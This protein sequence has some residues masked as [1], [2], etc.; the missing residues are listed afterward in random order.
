MAKPNVLPRRAPNW[1]TCGVTK[2]P[3]HRP[4]SKPLSRHSSRS[5]RSINKRPNRSLLRRESV[6]R[7]SG[8][9]ART[10][11]EEPQPPSPAMHEA[12]CMICNS[13]YREEMDELFV[14]WHN[15]SEI[16]REYNTPR[17]TLYRHAHAVGLFPHP[18]SQ[19][20][21]FPGTHHPSRRNRPV[22]N[23][24]LRD[25]RRPHPRSH[26]RNRRVGQPAHARH[27]LLRNGRARKQNRASRARIARHTM[28]SNRKRKA[29]KTNHGASRRVTHI[30]RLCTRARLG[31]SGHQMENF[32]G[33]GPDAALKTAA[34]HINV[35][36]PA[37]KISCRYALRPCLTFEARVEHPGFRDTPRFR[38]SEA[39]RAV[40]R[41]PSA[42]RQFV[43]RAE[44]NPSRRQRRYTP[45]TM[46]MEN[47]G[48][49]GFSLDGAGPTKTEDTAISLYGLAGD[50]RDPRVTE[51]K[52]RA[53]SEKNFGGQGRTFRRLAPER[54]LHRNPWSAVTALLRIPERFPGSS[55]P[56]LP[57][58]WLACGRK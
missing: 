15:V 23:R 55:L 16:A 29:M 6:S 25:S 46:N 39:H 12:Q 52:G 26:Q 11:T 49:F 1:S 22:P 4:K 18:R 27:R 19:P 36:Q 41:F 56:R 35:G 38:A 28:S 24:R 37:L 3:S 53:S 45:E 34:L 47:E 20:S 31:F 13:E 5:R 44:Q 8:N 17:R 21:T 7:K 2:E 30:S 14:N 58:G 57:A 43:R 32:W 9:A 48:S 33:P 42:P 51:G 40:P 54:A 10:V 50:A